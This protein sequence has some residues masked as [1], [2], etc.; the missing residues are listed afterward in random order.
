MI[1]KTK[2]NVKIDPAVKD[3]FPDI[4]LT[5]E[6]QDIAVANDFNLSDGLLKVEMEN[7]E[8]RKK[9]KERKETAKFNKM[10][11]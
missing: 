8:K 9:A 6:E 1:D 10:Y 3:L 4:A 2:S 5:K 7:K 11:S